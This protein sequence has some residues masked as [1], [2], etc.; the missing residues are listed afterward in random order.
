MAKPRSRLLYR[1]DKVVSQPVVKRQ[2]VYPAREVYADFL[3]RELKQHAGDYPLYIVLGKLKAVY[4]LNRNTVFFGKSCR[5]CRRLLG[6][7]VHTVEQYDKRLVYSLKLIY[8]PFLGFLVLASRNIA[9]TAV[10]RY[11]KSYC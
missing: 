10:G 3:Y 9:Y 6:L 4:R 7:G 8:H 11:H 5:G 2:R 1:G